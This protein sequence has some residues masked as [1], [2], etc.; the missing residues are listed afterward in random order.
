MRKIPIREGLFSGGVSGDL[1]GVKCNGCKRILPP[2]SSIC[3]YCYGTDLK[4]VK[5]SH[6]GKLYS[7]TDIYQPHKHFEVPYSV[8][9]IDLPEGVRIFTPL[10]RKQ[11][12]LFYVG[13]PMKLL[14]ETLWGDKDSEVV[15]PKFEPE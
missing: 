5:L 15:G 13:M 10:K 7:Y 11:G 6:H 14:V 2:L 8:G 3:Y 1:M 4:N 12:E 9:Y